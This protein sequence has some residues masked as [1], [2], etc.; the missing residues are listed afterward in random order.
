MCIGIE[1]KCKFFFIFAMSQG[2]Y[3]VWDMHFIFA[4]S[5]SNGIIILFFT[6]NDH[7]KRLL[8]QYVVTLCCVA[9]C[10]WILCHHHHR[11]QK[12]SFY[13]NLTRALIAWISND[14]LKRFDEAAQVCSFLSDCYSVVTIRKRWRVISFNDDIT[15]DIGFCYSNGKRKELFTQWKA[16]LSYGNPLLLP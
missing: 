11:H 3:I 8:F 16:L 14:K 7:F 9:Y 13:K 4:L 1:V 6:L 15:L 12:L 5:Q 10:I 2:W